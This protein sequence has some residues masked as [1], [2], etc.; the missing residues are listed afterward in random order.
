M[1]VASAAV[2]PSADEE[3]WRYSR[4]GELDLAAFEPAAVKS[5]VTGAEK[6]PAVDESLISRL[7]AGLT[8]H[9]SFDELSAEFNCTVAISVPSG[10]VLHEPIVV[11]HHIEGDAAALYPRLVV[12]GG[13]NSEFTVVERFESSDDT[14]ALV[15]PRLV[16]QA[17]QAAR[18]SYL[19][20]NLLGPR[21]WQLAHQ[22]ATGE[23]D[24]TTLLATVALG[25]DYARVRTDARLVGQGATTKQ[26]ALYYADGTQMHDFRTLQDHVAPR[27]NSD[28]LFKGAVQDSAKSV[29]TG[30]IRI[31]EDAK[32]SVAFQTNRNLTLSEGAWAESVPNLDIRTNDVKCSHASTVGPI[33]EE[34]RFYLESRGIPPDVAER[35]VVLGFFDDVL[36]LLP[37]G[38]LRRDLRARVAAKLHH[39]DSR[40]GAT[41]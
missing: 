11:T 24:S 28:L 40:A 13:A 7:V 25:G 41:R 35:L 4:I 23:R 37:V 38:E 39:V 6:L 2:L 10:I 33:D 30:L 19:G 8:M 22:Q 27:T 21:V 32:G 3:V 29:Y 31:R 36:A 5:T 15:V 18:V 26:V 12:H 20:I 9:D 34:Q 14:R 16:L 1:T 17:D